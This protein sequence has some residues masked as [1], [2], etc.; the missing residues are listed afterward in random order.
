MKWQNKNIYTHM[1]THMHTHTHTH[2]H[3]HRGPTSI[4]WNEME[5]VEPGDVV[6]TVHINGLKEADSHPH[7]Q[8]DQ[9]VAEQKDANEEASS[10]DC[11]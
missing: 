10:K 5:R 8:E 3:T 9:V 4:E 7:P 11:K 2:T 6:S 1:H